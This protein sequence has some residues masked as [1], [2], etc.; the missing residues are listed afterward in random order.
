MQ[1]FQYIECPNCRSSSCSVWA[2]ESGFKVVRCDQCA[3][4]YVSP[5]PRDDLI[6]DAVRTG[7]HQSEYRDLN[8]AGRRNARKVNRYRHLFR[9][10]FSDLWRRSAGISWLD[11]GAGYGEVV[12]AVTSLAPPGSR[13]R[14]LEPMRPKVEN[15]RLRGLEVEDAYLSS[16]HGPVDVIS[17]VDVFSH[18]PDFDSFLA[19]ARAA[20][21]DRGELFIETG[22]LADLKTREEFPEELRLPDHLIFA[23]ETQ[24]AQYLDRAGMDISEMRR[25]RFDTAT[26]FAKS[27]A[28]KLI[29]RPVIVRPPYS[30]S[31]CSLQIRARKRQ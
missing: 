31:Y 25:E 16:A 13:V 23:G 5:R 1:E 11:V 18:I 4:L 29:G 30:S 21:R 9:G 3:L 20:L 28:K 24:L 27:I 15:A 8:V 19:T 12:E 2:E 14:G 26:Y 22:N 6:A 7:V 17:L 10:L